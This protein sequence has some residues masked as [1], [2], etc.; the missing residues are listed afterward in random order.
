MFA[1][2]LRPVRPRLIGYDVV[3]HLGA[4][5][6]VR[7]AP[8]ILVQRLD[9]QPVSSFIAGVQPAQVLAEIADL[10][11]RIPCRQLHFAL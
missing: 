11:E 7:D 3:F 9:R 1:V 10:V 2:H 4:I 6:G 5:F 8:G